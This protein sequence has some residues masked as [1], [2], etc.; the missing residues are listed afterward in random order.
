MVVHAFPFD[1]V[2]PWLI[3]ACD[4]AA[5]K[6]NLHRAWS[7]RDTRVR[8]VKCDV[9]SYTPGSRAAMIYEVLSESKTTDFPELRHLVGKMHA[10]RPAARLFAGS[11]AVWR[12]L[13]GRVGL[14]PPVGYVGP[15]NLWL[16]EFINGSRLGDLAGSNTFIKP[17]RQTASG[18]AAVHGAAMPLT[19]DRTIDK[20]LKSIR[21]W[22]K[23]LAKIRPAEAD[24]VERLYEGVAASLAARL[25]MKGPVHG[26][27][28]LANVLAHDDTIT[29]IDMD[30]LAFGDPLVDVGRFLAALRIS[31]LRVH[32]KQDGLATAG[33]AFLE[34]YLKRTGADESRARLFEAA[35]L[36]TSA[37]SSF[38]MQR[39]DW[40]ESA[41]TILAEAEQAFSLSRR[42]STVPVSAPMEEPELGFDDRIKWASDGVYMQARLDPYIADAYD[43]EIR[44]C[45]ALVRAHTKKNCHIRYHLKGWR[46]GT[47]WR[48]ALDGYVWRDHTGRHVVRRLEALKKALA[49]TENKPLLPQKLV[50]LTSPSILVLQAPPGTPFSSVV[51]TTDGPTMAARVARALSALHLS[52]AEFSTPRILNDEIAL[53]RRQ[54]KRLRRS[55]IMSE[56]RWIEILSKIDKQVTAADQRISPILNVHN[57]RYIL[58]NDKHIGFADFRGLA[59]SN[60]L[61]DV[62]NFLAQFALMG[63]E[64]NAV[65]VAAAVAEKFRDAYIDAGSIGEHEIPPF[66][67]LALLRLACHQLDA[68]SDNATTKSLVECAEDRMGC[69]GGT[70]YKRLGISTVKQ[71]YP[72][73]PAVQNPFVFIVGCSRSGTTLL[74]RMINAHSEVA[75]PLESHWITKYYEE[76]RG[77]TPDGHVQPNLLRHL[78][79]HRKFS[80]LKFSRDELESLIPSD[81]AISY[82]DFVSAIYD[83][84][85]R[86]KGKKLVGDKTPPYTRQIPLLHSLWPKSKFVHI[87]RDGRDVGL[88]VLNWKRA[89]TTVGRIGTWHEHPVSTVA[90]WWKWYVR[91]G[92]EGGRALGP[93]LYYELRYEALLENPERECRGVCNFLGLRFDSAMLTYHENRTKTDPGL[94]AKAAWLPPTRG[95]RNWKTQMAEEDLEKFEAA[96]GDLLD[97]LGYQRGITHLS[98]EAVTLAKEVYSRFDGKPLPENW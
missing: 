64:D 10:R 91:L 94:D 74:K 92:R 93:D 63:I 58:C 34:Q 39:P 80:K 70:S 21:R 76:R 90:L 89:R 77:L 78:L 9:L 25:R 6:V 45:N 42:G 73:S 81:G 98:A 56:K 40:Q 31:A 71:T 8:R 37:V 62:G 46:N 1:P 43:A 30:Q 17:V 20:E 19:S 18:I 49:G 59:I 27:F 47:R 14:A 55:G 23:I 24:R 54:V 15:A 66:E 28:H 11:W 44:S 79:K 67:A 5:M 41:D 32:G 36:I 61:I 57:L 88:S 7:D 72:T 12:A 68:D 50:N 95:L 69:Y 16:Q 33:E 75:I 52:G 60:P 48:H 82:T 22:S 97:E 86:R 4:P 38:R 51:K 26:D 29:L 65:A 13:R 83:L 87:I 2:L 96:G 85:G 53:P 84:Y 3:D 35:S